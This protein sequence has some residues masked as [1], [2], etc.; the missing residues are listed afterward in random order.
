[1]PETT[2]N[3]KRA[4]SLNN[5]A[6]RAALRRSNVRW[7]ELTETYELV[8]EHTKTIQNRDRTLILHL[9]PSTRA[10]GSSD[11][12]CPVAALNRYLLTTSNR[13]DDE[14][15]F[16]Y[17]N[18]ANQW[19]ILDYDKFTAIFKHKLAAIGIDPSLYAG[20]SFRRGGATFA[21]AYA[22]L[23][24][25]AIKAM[26][27]WASNAFLL[28]CEVQEQERVNAARKMAAATTAARPSTVAAVAEAAA[29]AQQWQQQHQQR[30]RARTQQH[31]ADPP[32][33]LRH[34]LFLQ[35]PNSGR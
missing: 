2:L 14:P 11:L 13:P 31:G 12:L 18:H 34:R 8:L 5:T 20:H 16:G 33:S 32:P 6:E 9:S 7:N 35:P 27:D 24:T 22:R 4:T 29:A 3:R 30:K 25:T 1:M 10:D 28:Y 21:F 23:S 15:L 26:G 19:I 17:Y